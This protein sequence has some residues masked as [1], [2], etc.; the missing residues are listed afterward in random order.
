MSQ[1]EREKVRFP[2]AHAFLAYIHERYMVTF[3]RL[4]SPKVLHN[5]PLPVSSI[6][7]LYR[8]QRAICDRF[9]LRMK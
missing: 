4:D 9:H 2:D 1:E 6:A 3:K 8:D 5:V 7:C